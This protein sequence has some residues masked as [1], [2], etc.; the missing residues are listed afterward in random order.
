MGFHLM[1]MKRRRVVVFFLVMASFIYLVLSSDDGK[2]KCY[3]PWHAHFRGNCYM[4]H[5]SIKPFSEAKAICES[6]SDE[7]GLSHMVSIHDNDTNNFLV[8]NVVAKF[9]HVNTW[10][11]LEDVYRNGSFSWVDGSKLDYNN[12]DEG[13]PDNPTLETCAHL[14]NQWKGDIPLTWNDIF[15][16]QSFHFI[17]QKTFIPKEQYCMEGR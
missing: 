11:G 8:Q 7:R 15:C 9:G 2:C 12:F 16:L 14:W 5:S 10:I 4:F 6:Y 1:S 3:R 13:K 17:C